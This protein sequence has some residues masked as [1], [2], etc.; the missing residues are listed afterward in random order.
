MVVVA[1]GWTGAG[2]GC[3]GEEG[4]AQRQW[5]CYW[6][7]LLR[8]WR[9]PGDEELL[10][11]VPGRA[12]GIRRRLERLPFVLTMFP[13]ACIVQWRKSVVCLGVVWYKNSSEVLARRRES[14]G[15]GVEVVPRLLVP[16][17]R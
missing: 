14:R 1:R 12:V 13:V 11:V 2:V 10:A 7:L 6:H 9:L 16:Q 15:G 17:P 8:V 5:C 4:V 3:A